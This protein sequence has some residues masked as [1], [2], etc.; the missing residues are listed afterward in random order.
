M[1]RVS[2][3]VAKVIKEAGYPQELKE[4]TIFYCENGLRD[5]YN[6]ELYELFDPMYCV[7]PYV[8][9]VWLWLWREKGIRFDVED[10]WD[11]E[12]SYPERGCASN[13]NQLGGIC[14]PEVSDPEEAIEKA[15]KC[16]VTND[17]LK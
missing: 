4:G 8:L 15:I 13:T 6:S 10:L 7:C 2:F 5:K 14:T 12:L 9:D 11:A 17:L 1:E 16:L 3:A